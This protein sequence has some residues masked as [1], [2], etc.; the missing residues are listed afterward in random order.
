MT[1]LAQKIGEDAKSHYIEKMGS[2]R[3]KQFY[4]LWTE[5]IWLHMKWGEYV[6]LFG[7]G[8]NRLE[9]LNETA[10]VFFWMVENVLWEDLLLHISRLTD[11]P[12]TCGKLNL[13][14]QNL[15]RFID[16]SMKEALDKLIAMALEKTAFAR[17]WRNRRLAHLDLDLAIGNT[18]IRPLKDAT[19]MQ[20]LD[21][22]TAIR[23]VFIGLEQQYLCED[24]AYIGS[25]TQRGATDLLSVLYFGI[26]EQTK[27]NQRIR[28]GLAT[29]D[30][31]P[32]LHLRAKTD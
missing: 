11:P 26:K 15:P 16:A 18:E 7:A 31:Y 9:L 2:E 22:L 32:A 13:T 8:P 4:A 5:M 17:D 12:E 10:P 14:I 29:E 28:D 23:D 21:A 3:G 25:I 30:D 20:M 19:K 24:T 1:T 27:A 6:D